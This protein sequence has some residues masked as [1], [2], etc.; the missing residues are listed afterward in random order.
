MTPSLH[1]T[2][3]KKE[4]HSPGGKNT[5]LPRK[6]ILDMGEVPQLK[7]VREEKKRHAGREKKVG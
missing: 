1:K 7:R 2:K 6:F 4:R 5:V 3:D